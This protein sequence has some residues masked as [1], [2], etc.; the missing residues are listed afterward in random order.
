MTDYISE[1]DMQNFNILCNN[2]IVKIEDYME[3]DKFVAQIL[4]EPVSN[5]VKNNIKGIQK[6]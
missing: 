4:N 3:L 5:I 6:T 2:K 1:E